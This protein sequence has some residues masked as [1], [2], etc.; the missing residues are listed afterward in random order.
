MVVG[1]GPGRRLT[2]RNGCNGDLLSFRI[3]SRITLRGENDGD[4]KTWFGF[5]VNGVKSMFG[6]SLSIFRGEVHNEGRKC[7]GHTRATSARSVSSLRRSIRASVSGSPNLTL[8]SRT[9]GP[10][11]VTMKP[12]NKI[13]TNGKPI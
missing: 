5:D 12:V 6:A 1:C 10:S 11:L 2:R 9:F 8:Y 3:T 13:P 4:G 7:H